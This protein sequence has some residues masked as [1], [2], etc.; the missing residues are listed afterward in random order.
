M[1]HC[2]TQPWKYNGTDC[3]YN[4]KTMLTYI[5]NMQFRNW[6]KTLGTFNI[7]TKFKDVCEC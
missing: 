6:M 2:F 4:C 1:Y 5:L 7:C 3:T